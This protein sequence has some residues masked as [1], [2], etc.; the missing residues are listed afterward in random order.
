MK[1]PKNGNVGGG[2]NMDKRVHLFM[3]DYQ[4]EDLG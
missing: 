3:E 2:I 4:I 1:N